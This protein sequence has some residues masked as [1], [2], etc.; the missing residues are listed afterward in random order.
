M[1]ARV[2]V[3]VSGGGTNLQALLD[4][5]V[6]GPWIRIVVSDRPSIPALERAER[7]GIETSVIELSEY[8]DRAAFTRAVRDLLLGHEIDVV[9]NA[10]YMKVLTVE[11]AEAF[12]GRWLNVHPSLLPAFPG[13]HSVADAL[14]HGVKVTGVTVHL[15]DEEV[16]HGPIVA[17]ES[18]PVYPDDDWVMLEARVHQVEHRLLP[19]AVRAFVEGRMKLEGRVVRVL[20]AID[21]LGD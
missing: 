20:E 8:A 4:D 14:A 9:A 11:F 3:L 10:G 5:V 1:D 13:C 6:V 2:A 18:V 17:Q 19:A 15:V 16:D 7:R 12:E 21:D